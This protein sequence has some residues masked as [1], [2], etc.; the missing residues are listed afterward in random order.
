MLT[1]G[2]RRTVAQLVE[3]QWVKSVPYLK[4]L[5]KKNGIDP[6]EGF[7]EIMDDIR[8]HLNANQILKFWS[9][10]FPLKVER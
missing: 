3:Q 5:L 6:D 4:R 1:A 2:Q 7:V 8:F 10:Q 9:D